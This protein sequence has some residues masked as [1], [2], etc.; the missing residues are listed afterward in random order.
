MFSTTDVKESIKSRLN[1]PLNSYVENMQ[2]VQSMRETIY[3]IF[4]LEC[5]R[6]PCTRCVRELSVL[7]RDREGWLRNSGRGGPLSASLLLP[8]TPF[9]LSP[10]LF[11]VWFRSVD[12]NAPARSPK[13]ACIAGY[14]IFKHGKSSWPPI[15][16]SSKS[17]SNQ[18]SKSKVCLQNNFTV[19]SKFSISL[20]MKIER[21]VGKG[22]TWN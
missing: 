14:R 2:A 9:R 10:S 11:Q 7:A 13:Y 17:I 8:R 1:W 12:K 5:R 3:R 16:S 20:E 4:S 18:Q 19:Q 15:K 21:A 6:F 22:T